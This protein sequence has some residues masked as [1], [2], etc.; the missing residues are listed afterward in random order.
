M[1]KTLQFEIRRREFLIT[2]SAIA[3]AFSKYDSIIT[4]AHAAPED[5]DAF[6]TAL[7]IERSADEIIGWI[8]TFPDRFRALAF[9]LSRTADE[10]SDM[11]SIARRIA[12]GEENF[13]VPIINR[14]RK[15]RPAI[16]KA[17]V[18]PDTPGI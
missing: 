2:L 3:A 5:I 8:P 4:F 14:E 12:S 18:E 11:L 15:S 16:T 1:R 13:P 9:A 10:T 17:W 6:K 7:Q